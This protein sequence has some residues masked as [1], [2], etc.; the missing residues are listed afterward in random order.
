MRLVFVPAVPDPEKG[1]SPHAAGLVVKA[2]YAALDC[3]QQCQHLLLGT[4]RSKVPASGDPDGIS[5]DAIVKTFDRTDES[6]LTAQLNAIACAARLCEMESMHAPEWTAPGAPSPTPWHD[7]AKSHSTFE[8]AMGSF[9]L[10]FKVC[11]CHS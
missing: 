5:V 4:Q 6:Q 9:M 1:H 10:A 2:L 7:F 8:Y 11:H 3:P